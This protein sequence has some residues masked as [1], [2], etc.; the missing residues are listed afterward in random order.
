MSCV[1]T[2]N[3]E[4]VSVW[5]KGN[6]GGKNVIKMNVCVWLWGIFWCSHAVYMRM[7][8]V[9]ACSI[10]VSRRALCAPFAGGL[11]ALLALWAPC[12]NPGRSVPHP[13]GM[14]CSVQTAH[15]V[16]SIPSNLFMI[17]RL[18]KGHFTHTVTW[19]PIP[20]SLHAADAMQKMRRVSFEWFHL[21]DEHPRLTDV[22]CKIGRFS[23]DFQVDFCWAVFVEQ[24]LRNVF[25]RQGHHS[26]FIGWYRSL[27]K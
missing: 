16:V 27:I 24:N 18:C 9:L 8:P 6:W 10:A 14:Q 22:P 25:L 19:V 3:A 15:E 11:T 1:H 21:E 13:T 2:D 7:V 12:S 5:F 4:S 23:Q 26:F 17:R 20:R